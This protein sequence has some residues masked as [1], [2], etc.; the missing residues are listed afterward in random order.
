MFVFLLMTFVLFADNSRPE[1]N[2]VNLP[3]KKNTFSALQPEIAVSEI[4]NKSFNINTLKDV[5][6]RYIFTCAYFHAP[7]PE[8]QRAMPARAARTGLASGQ[9][10]VKSAYFALQ[11]AFACATAACLKTKK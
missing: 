8:K 11:Q 7:V 2:L 1:Q 5:A 4:Q 3:V 10:D 9:M 6:P